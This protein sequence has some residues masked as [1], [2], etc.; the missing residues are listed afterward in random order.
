MSVNHSLFFINP[1]AGGGTGNV[2]FRQEKHYGQHMGTVA[3]LG[4]KH[5]S[6]KHSQ[7]GSIRIPVQWR[8]DRD[9]LVCVQHNPPVPVGEFG[10]F[11]VPCTV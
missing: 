6:A 1:P 10:H 11:A 8:A 3:A 9:R 5:T 2:L 4:I 7:T